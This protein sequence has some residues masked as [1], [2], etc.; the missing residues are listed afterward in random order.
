MKF[1]D[2]HA[3]FVEPCV[4]CAAQA[5][6][7]ELAQRTLVEEDLAKPQPG[8]WFTWLADRLIARAKKTPYFHLPGYMNRWWLLPYAKWR[9]AARIHEILSSDDDRAF[10]DHPWPYITLI[11][12]NGYFEVKPVFKDGIYQGD[13]RTWY[14]P[15]SILFRRAR[16]WH[17]LEL[18]D[19]QPATTLFVTFRYQ[20]RWGFMPQPTMNKIDYQVYLGQSPKRNPNDSASVFEGQA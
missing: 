13:T 6:A 4:R 7:R 19:G 11:L 18:K 3:N 20:Q 15:G 16:S 17:R 8:S 14:G 10:H 2:K 1:C 9:P 5:A 12:K